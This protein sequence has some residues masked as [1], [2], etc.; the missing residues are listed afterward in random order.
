MYRLDSSTTTV[1]YMVD[2]FNNTN[3]FTTNTKDYGENIFG[4]TNMYIDYFEYT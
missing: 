4:T 3:K 2:P 1:L